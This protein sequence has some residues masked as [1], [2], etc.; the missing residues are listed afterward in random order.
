M[1]FSKPKPKKKKPNFTDAK[2]VPAQHYND[3][4]NFYTRALEEKNALIT[5]LKSDNE[6]LM[7]SLVRKS[8]KLVDLE[9]QSIKT[10]DQKVN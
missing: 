4:I 7:R 5:K 8:G 6:M 10:K 9:S 3:M 1:L 2:S